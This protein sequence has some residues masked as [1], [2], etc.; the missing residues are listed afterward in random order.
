ML[1][2]L[3][4]HLLLWLF[5]VFLGECD[6]PSLCEGLCEVRLFLGGQSSSF[7][8]PRMTSMSLTEFSH[9]IR[10]PVKLSNDPAKRQVN[11]TFTVEPLDHA[12]VS[13][14]HEIG[15][16]LFTQ[17]VLIEENLKFSLSHF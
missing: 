8:S 7:F 3:R 17:S 11:R 16:I 6:D 10:V 1:V 12:H 13:N 15:K 14:P 9:E 4:V 2:S 5:E